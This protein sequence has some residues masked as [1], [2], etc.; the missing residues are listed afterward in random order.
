MRY[1]LRLAIVA[2]LTLT[3]PLSVFADVGSPKR[4]VRQVN[5]IV[6]FMTQDC[7]DPAKELKSPLKKSVCK[8]GQECNTYQN[9]PP[10]T[11][12]L[13]PALPAPAY[14]AVGWTAPAVSSHLLESLWRPPRSLS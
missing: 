12:T 10:S 1:Y 2:L 7:C 14:V 3:L 9:Y 4:C 6:V 8:T 11:L 13:A 5:G